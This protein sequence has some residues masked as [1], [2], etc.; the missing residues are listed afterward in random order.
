MNVDGGNR[1]CILVNINENNICRDVTYERNR[2][3]MQGYTN[4]KGE[5]VAGLGNSL[6]Y[7]KTAFVGNNTAASATDEDKVALALKAGN[8]I[9]IAENTLE[10]IKTTDSYQI[11]QN[12]D[13]YTAIYFTGNLEHFAEYA[14]KVE[15][16]RN[17][18]RL[19]QVSAYIYCI[20]NVDVFESEFNK[21]TPIPK[22][23][24]V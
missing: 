19:V 21:L 2:R 8:L 17:S 24:P 1:Q 11:F 15:E 14:Q 13:K 12:G 3:V 6:K 7:Y 5:Q 16:I 20:G 22:A 10:E 9:A 18:S 4:S 23:K